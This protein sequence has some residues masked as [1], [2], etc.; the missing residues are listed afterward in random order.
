MGDGNIFNPGAAGLSVTAFTSYVDATGQ[1][2]P[3]Y[4][5]QVQLRANEA[6][7][8]GQLIGLVGATATVPLSAEPLD[9][10]DAFAS[11]V[12]FGVAAEAAAAAGDLVSIVTDGPVIVNIDDTGACVLGDVVIKHATTDGAAGNGGTLGGTWDAADVAGT[13]LGVYLGPEIG[14]SNQAPIWFRKF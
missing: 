8:A 6:I 4:R 14:T 1:V 11:L 10:S 7:A 13:A 9:V 12:C 5:Q 3:Y 2:L